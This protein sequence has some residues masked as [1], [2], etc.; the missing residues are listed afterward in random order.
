MITAKCNKCGGTALGVTFEEAS[1]KINHAVGMSRGIKCGANY[2]HVYEVKPPV[3]KKP[4]VKIEK[5]KVPLTD[6]KPKPSVTEKPKPSVTE[7]P[8]P[9]TVTKPKPSK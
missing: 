7:K 1:S 2:N 9:P 4:P 8:K 6:T 3:S 5:P